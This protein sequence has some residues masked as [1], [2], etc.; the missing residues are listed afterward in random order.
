MMPTAERFR[1]SIKEDARMSLVVNYNDSAFNAHRNLQA[2]DRMLKTSIQ[3]LSSGLRVNNASDDPAGLVISQQMRGQIEG[4]DRAINNANDGVNL[5]KTAE[6]ALN[7]VHS[8][9]TQMRGLAVHAANSG[10]NSTEAVAADQAQ[11][12]K[13]VESIDRIASTT[14]FNGK[15]L[16]D[17]TYTNQV[18]QIGANSSDSVAVSITNQDSTTL[19]VNALNLSTSAGAA[20][21]AIDAAIQ[22]VSDTRSTLGSIQKDTLE[23]TINSLAIARENIAGA[24]STI[25]DA[26]ISAEMVTFTRNNIM[27]QAGTAMLAQANSAP[28]TVLQLLR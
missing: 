28:Q 27:L 21:D 9:L 24:E 25:R 26:D 8:L 5:V 11:L 16:L 15:S 20:I 19:A 10:V 17:G 14:R 6:A 13:A 22:T 18:F 7:E 12:D 23:T 1:G 3:H 4:M 2:T